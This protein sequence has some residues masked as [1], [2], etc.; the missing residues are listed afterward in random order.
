MRISECSYREMYHKVMAIRFPT[1]SNYLKSLLS[2]ESDN[3]ASESTNGAIVYGYI[4]HE[5]GLSF[6]LLAFAVINNDG[7]VIMQQH[8]STVSTR[9]RY[10]AVQDC[11]VIF[12]ID[13]KYNM[14]FSKEIASV[15]NAYTDSEIIEAFRTN[16]IF[17]IFDEFRSPEYPDDVIVLFY[18]END[19]KF[20]GCWVRLEAIDNKGWTYGVLLDTPWKDYGVKSDDYIR[21]KVTYIDESTV[22]LLYTDNLE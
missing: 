9:I 21:F 19:G 2:L 10:G 4:D 20:E 17:K 11:I 12:D 5:C 6:Y 8:D 7:R 1:N 3:G 14:F 22:K 18:D 15:N 16:E 13:E